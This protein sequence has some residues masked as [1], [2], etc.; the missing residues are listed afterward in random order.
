MLDTR[1]KFRADAQ[2]STESQANHVRTR[3]IDRKSR[4][5]GASGKTARLHKAAVAELVA[6]GKGGDVGDGGVFLLGDFDHRLR[7][8]HTHHLGH[9]AGGGGGGDNARAGR[10]VQQ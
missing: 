8:V 6:D 10:D 4:T 7:R 3:R 2:Y 9:A 5:T 1:K